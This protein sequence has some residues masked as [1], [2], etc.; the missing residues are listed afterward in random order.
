[1][2]SF[3]AFL[4]FA[5]L[6]H[7]VSRKRL[8]VV[9]SFYIFGMLKLASDLAERQG[10]WPLVITSCLLILNPFN[11]GLKIITIC[12]SFGHCLIRYI[13]TFEALYGCVIRCL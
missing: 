8:I 11:L 2:G 7:V 10:P 1:M 13:E 12:I 5:D 9:L 3:G 6:V 4:I